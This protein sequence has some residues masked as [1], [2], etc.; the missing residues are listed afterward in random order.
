MYREDSLFFLAQQTTHTQIRRSVCACLC[1]V[2][3]NEIIEK[4]GDKSSASILLPL[5][6]GKCSPESID[7]LRNTHYFTRYLINRSTLA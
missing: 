5:F 2:T 7:F 4:R 3:A 6:L 1:V